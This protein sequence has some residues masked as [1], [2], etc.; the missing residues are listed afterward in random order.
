[1]GDRPADRLCLVLWVP[2]PHPHIPHRLSFVWSHSSGIIGF[3]S[4]SHLRCRTCSPSPHLTSAVVRPS[5]PHI[6]EAVVQS[7][8]L[9]RLCSPGA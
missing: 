1:V 6:W 7:I 4:T 8:I 5:E 2:D 9:E 3:V